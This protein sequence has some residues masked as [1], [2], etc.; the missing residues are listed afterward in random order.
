MGGSVK[1]FLHHISRQLRIFTFLIADH[2]PS[3]VELLLDF[4]QGNEKIATLTLT[5]F[6]LYVVFYAKREF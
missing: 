5:C 6:P 3:S 2:F 4:F 1:G